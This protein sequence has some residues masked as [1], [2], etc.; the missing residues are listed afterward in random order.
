[1][2]SPSDAAETPAVTD[3]LAR[4]IRD[5]QYDDVPAGVQDL[6]K[7]HILDALGLSLA[8]AATP[9]SAIIND[10]I[11][12]LNCDGQSHIFGTD[13]VTAPQ[14]AALANGSAIHAHDYDDTCPQHLADRNGG[15]HATG[16]VISAA[17]AMAEPSGRSGRA[18]L[19]AFHVGVEV[20]CRINH[21]IDNRH[22]AGGYHASGTVNV[23]GA[24]AAASRTMR[25]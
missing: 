1:M 19:E 17:L 20:G 2:T 13:L 15:L 22:Y 14:F 16:P 25:A 10:H 12:A 24:A 8:G 6:A 4:F 9:G 23:F 3:H 21:A 7:G 18:V 11:A 5:T